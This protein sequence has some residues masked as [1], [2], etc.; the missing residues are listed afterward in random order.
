MKASATAL[1]D[2]IMEYRLKVGEAIKK[3]R[4][5]R[6]H[7]QDELAVLMNI[8]RST[9]SKVENGKFAMS[10]DYLA[11]FGWYLKFDID[12]IQKPLKK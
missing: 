7:S 5:K 11:K 1:D 6:G 8:S 3:T 2:F 12:L 4:E 9:I 10:V